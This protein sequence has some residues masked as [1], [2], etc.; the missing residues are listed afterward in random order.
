MLKQKLKELLFHVLETQPGQLFISRIAERIFTL[1]HAQIES[2]PELKKIYDHQLW[3]GLVN[4]K[5]IPFT[6]HRNWPSWVNNQ[7]NPD[8]PHFNS[9]LTAYWVNNTS[10]KNWTALSYPNTNA[11][12]VV[13]AQNLISPLPQNW[14]LES[15][16]ATKKGL[17]S[18]SNSNEIKQVL[19]VKNP[20]IISS[21]TLNDITLLSE[22]FLSPI[23]QKKTILFTKFQLKN[24][25][26]SE[27]KMFILYRYSTL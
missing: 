15:F 25:T 3:Q 6:L 19:D 14:S 22:T 17:I 9:H 11:T 4:L 18:S 10:N 8:S 16:I 13:D 20:K 23:N 7:F 5:V 24:E 21:C 1:P 26:N 27:K 12:V 2:N